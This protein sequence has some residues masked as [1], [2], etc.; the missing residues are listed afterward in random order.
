MVKKRTY[1][2]I[3]WTPL[4]D[5]LFY[6]YELDW[7]HVHRIAAK[8]RNNK[9]QQTTLGPLRIRIVSKPEKIHQVKL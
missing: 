9:S 6:V 7:D 8:A 4:Y 1:K 3:G 5:G 2:N